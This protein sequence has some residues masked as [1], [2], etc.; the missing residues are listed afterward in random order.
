MRFVVF[1]E[2]VMTISALTVANYFLELAWQESKQLTN[3]QLQK[4][5]YF[6]HGAKLAVIGEPLIKED[7][8]AWKMGPVI[9]ELYAK[10]KR[11]GSGSIL[12]PIHVSEPIPSNVVDKQCIEFVWSNFKDYTGIQLSSISH[13]D[14]TPWKQVWSPNGFFIEIP[15]NLTQE[16]YKKILVPQSNKTN[17]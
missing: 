2:I 10:L 6:A 4:L 9:P 16:Y 14:G 15:N 11:Y 1:K 12:D 13:A 8:N 5:V 3:M 7:V 17:A